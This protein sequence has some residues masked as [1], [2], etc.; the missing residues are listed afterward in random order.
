[1]TLHSCDH[2]M[3]VGEV[4]NYIDMQDELAKISEQYRELSG[5]VTERQKTL[6]RITDELE[7]VKQE[8]EER[9]SSMT[10]GSKS[11]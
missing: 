4:Y 6:A 5:G 10:D 2:R 9:G 11:I 3:K 8:M 1:M 7:T